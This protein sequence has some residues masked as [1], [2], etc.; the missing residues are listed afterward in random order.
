LLALYRETGKKKYL[1]PIPRALE[2]LRKCSFERNGKRVLARFYELKTNRPLYITPG[3]PNVRK[4]TY[5]AENIKRGYS[6]FT[7]AKPLERIGQEYE[8]LLAAKPEAIKRGDK[9]MSLKPFT[10]RRR[11]AVSQEELGGKVEAVIS[12]IDERGVW[13]EPKREGNA[14]GEQAERVISSGTFAR[15]VKILCDYLT[16]E[17][18]SGDLIISK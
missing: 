1:E 16:A 11:G 14:G 6:F 18:E 9:L 2:Y 12:S 17:N 10:Y 13:L 7:N 5:S 15:N 8:E 4:I 3:S